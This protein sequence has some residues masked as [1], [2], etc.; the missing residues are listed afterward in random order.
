MNCASIPAGLLESELFGHERGAF[1]GAFAQRIGR[2]ELATRGTLFLDEVGEIPLELQAKFLRVL[3]ERE[4]ERLGGSCTVKTDVRVVAATNCD[5]SAM[6]GE[7][8]FRADLYYRLNVFPIKLPPL[9]ERPDDIPL[10]AHHFL[11][12]F[13]RRMNKRVDTIPLAALEA[14]KRYHWPGNIRELQNTIERAVIL[15]TGTVLTLPARKLEWASGAGTSSENGNGNLRVTLHEMER[16]E[17]SPHWSRRTG[18]CPAR[19]EP[20]LCSV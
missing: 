4:F 14:L 18:R 5:L 9:R 17:S 20:P 15:S 12:Q 13:S 2:F 8:Q 6:V 1:T 11:A 7:R 16:K 3:Q 10:L 19:T